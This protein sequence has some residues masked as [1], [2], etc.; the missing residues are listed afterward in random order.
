MFTIDKYPDLISMG[1]RETCNT[2]DDVVLAV[3]RSSQKGWVIF[4]I[5]HDKKPF[6]EVLVKPDG[7]E[8]QIKTT[9]RG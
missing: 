8:C 7:T 1:V 4:E 2:I 9:E 3:F 5:Q 6:A